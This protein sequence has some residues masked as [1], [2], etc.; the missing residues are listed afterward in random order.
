MSHT[1]RGSLCA[2]ILVTTAAAFAAEDDWGFTMRWM[3]CGCV[4]GL[5]GSWTGASDGYDYYDQTFPPLSDIAYMAV[6]HEADGA[7]GG[8]AGAYSVDRRAPFAADVTKTWSPLVVWCDPNCAED[9]IYIELV[10]YRYGPPPADRDYTLELT[11]LPAGV[12]DAPAVGTSWTLDPAK[13]FHLELPAFPT[14]DPLAGYH[15]TLTMG[16]P[17]PCAGALRGD[18]NCDGEVNFFDIDPFVQALAGPSA[19]AAVVDASACQFN[20]VNDIN[21]DSAVDVA[22]I[23]A[24]IVC[25][26]GGCP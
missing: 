21:G 26:T 23:D 11:Q 1:V 6:Y 5:V 20:C 19:W 18:A 16:A 25:L 7:W 10:P 17:D 9:V 13:D 15:F 24:F 4:Q 3:G 22:D 8:P 12:T 14:K 2:A